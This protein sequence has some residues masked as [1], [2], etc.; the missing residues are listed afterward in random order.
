[1][2]SRVFLAW[3]FLNFLA[4]CDEALSQEENQAI[5]DQ[6]YPFSIF[7]AFGNYAKRF[8]FMQPMKELFS[9]LKFRREK[10]IWVSY[11]CEGKIKLFQVILVYYSVICLQT[12]DLVYTWQLFAFFIICKNAN[13]FTICLQ[14]N[15]QFANNIE[16]I[17]WGLISCN[18]AIID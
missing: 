7:L 4:H 2:I 17:L 12:R 1:M 5:S 9:T 13:N 11:F 14:T 8:I 3:T 15:K 10:L 16:I 6:C 18:V